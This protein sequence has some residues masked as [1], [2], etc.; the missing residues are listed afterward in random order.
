MFLESFCQAQ[1]MVIEGNQKF[2]IWSP[3]IENN[4]CW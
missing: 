3:M 1:H 2:K 4:N